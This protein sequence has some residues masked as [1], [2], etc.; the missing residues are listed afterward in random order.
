MVLLDSF[1]M[2]LT[3]KTL[4]I[5]K[6]MGIPYLFLKQKFKWMLLYGELA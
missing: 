3:N 2:T 6:R 1:L 4:L 5:E